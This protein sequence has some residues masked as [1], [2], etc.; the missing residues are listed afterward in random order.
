MR[1]VRP[2][3]SHTWSSDT[4]HHSHDICYRYDT[5]NLAHVGFVAQLSL[6]SFLKLRRRER[7]GGEARR[8]AHVIGQLLAPI[9]LHKEQYKGLANPYDFEMVTFT[10]MEILFLTVLAQLVQV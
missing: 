9:K 5:K 4:R 2:W 8:G 1:P 3:T 10:I 6:F 7:R